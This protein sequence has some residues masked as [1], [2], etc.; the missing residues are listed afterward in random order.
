MVRQ[1]LE[2]LDL[3]EQKPSRDPPKQE[4][5]HE[6]NELVYEPFDDLSACNAQAD[7]WSRYDEDSYIVSN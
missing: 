4:P 3:W 6:N 1:I 7:A 5:S 2:H